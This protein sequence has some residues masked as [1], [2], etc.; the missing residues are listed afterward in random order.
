MF[1][2]HGFEA[3]SLDD[4]AE[5]VGVSRRTLF[6]Y[7]PS[8]NDIPWGQFSQSLDHFRDV[9]RAQPSDAPL[10]ATIKA[11]V[12]RFNDFDANARPSHRD[13][14]KL[15]LGSPTL[16]AHSA[17]RYTKWRVVI[18]EYVADRTGQ[19]RDS[20]LARVAGH[21]ALGL[22]LAAYEE[23]L[24]REDSDLQELLTTSFAELHHL[25]GTN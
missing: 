24:M 23:W 7:Y 12:L 18:A 25:L 1:L 3:T 22:A 17:V 4:I 21:V 8:K 15:I 11:A 20:L 2:R 5:A 13:R 6:R 19:A 9:L 16:R 10:A 14:M